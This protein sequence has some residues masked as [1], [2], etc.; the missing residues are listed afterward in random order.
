MPKEPRAITTTPMPI[1][2]EPEYK[3]IKDL[4]TLE[5]KTKLYQ[6]EELV[7][8]PAAVSLAPTSPD[9]W[10]VWPRR[11]QKNS[12]S[13]VYQARAKAAGILREQ[14]T[15]EYVE[16]SAADYKK[17][18]NAPDEGAYPIEAFDFWRTKGIGI[19]AL[20]PSQGMSETEI[21]AS[22][23]TDYE[24]KVADI[25]K[26]D[27]Y[28]ALPEYNFDLFLSTLKATGKPIPVGFY[29]TYKE[30]SQDVPAILE[31]SLTLGSAPV[32][33]EVCATP[34]YGIYKGKEG[35]TIEDSW[36]STGIE[37]KGVRFITREFFAK[38]NYLPGI[39]PTRFKTYEDIGVVPTKP[40]VKLV[41]DLDYGDEG[42]D[43]RDL[44]TVLKYEGYFPANHA[45]STYYLEL[46][47]RG[48]QQY[49]AAHGIVSTGTPETTGY[50]RVGAKT[51]AH[52]NNRYK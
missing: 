35:F 22:I 9:R 45:G 21:N 13:C 44:Q 46:T 24:K 10:K 17:R 32:R 28:Y 30:W 25:S 34:N 11:D 48:V 14:E 23:Q 50:G 47:Q 3:G 20:E 51:R 41:R 26:L 8:A 38:R 6:I 52:I 42:E 16:Y 40:K 19:E 36:G 39:V 1:F 27:A 49:Q 7:S 18:S 29:G 12:S 2:T 5:Q 33:H 37:G 4:G 43:V 31:A 15:G